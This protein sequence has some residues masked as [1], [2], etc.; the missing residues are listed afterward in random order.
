VPAI[1]TQTGEPD[2]TG[3]LSAFLS[4]IAR[5]QALAAGLPALLWLAG[6]A[7]LAW[8]GARLLAPATASQ[9]GPALLAAAVLA[10]VTVAV[11]CW[12]LLPP[13]WRVAARLDRQLGLHETLSTALE[14][15][16]GPVA[17]ALARKAG[18]TAAALEPARIV[19]LLGRQTLIALAFLAASGMFAGAVAFM[20]EHAITPDGPVEVSVQTK[21]PIEAEA[22]Q[23]LAELLA[24][25]SRQ[26]R[27][28]YLAAVSRQVEKLAEELAAG[29]APETVEADLAA[30]LEHARAGYGEDVPDWLQAEAGDIGAAL[31]NAQAAMEAQRKRRE[32]RTNAPA[33]D[34]TPVDMYNLARERTAANAELAEGDAPADTPSPEGAGGREDS[35]PSGSDEFVA[36][37]MQ[38]QKLQNA[39]SFSAG[40]AAQSGKG[41]SNIAGGGSQPLLD[42]SG[43]LEA[44]PDPTQDMALTAADEQ[45]DGH[46]RVFVPTAANASDATGTVDGATAYARF[47]A[48]VMHRQTVSPDAR[49]V[50]AR[51]F[52]TMPNPGD[53]AP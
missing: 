23:A 53:G 52:N 4:R 46:I 34:S 50:V 37:P 18:E 48:Q 5:R 28:D 17:R 49:P 44:M 39:G 13:R 14:A 1:A 36:S 32:A 8:A 40:G 15:G 9:L 12:R 24:Q 38:S 10:G 2:H 26:R 33:G 21:A 16:Q 45:Q 35:G 31:G 29:R 19:P 27:S 11:L 22:V 30:L 51:Y 25:E 6:V 20:P 47:A 3:S 41:E 7:L 42:D 43:F